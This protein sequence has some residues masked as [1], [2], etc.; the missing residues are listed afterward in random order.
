MESFLLCSWSTSC[1][2]FSFFFP[3]GF[4]ILRKEIKQSSFKKFSL[5]ILKSLLF[6]LIISSTHSG[7]KIT[8]IF[9]DLLTLIFCVWVVATCLSRHMLAWHPWRLK[10]G[11]RSLGTG[12]TEGYEWLCDYWELNLDHLQ[13]QRQIWTAE[14]SLI[15]KWGVNYVF[16]FKENGNLHFLS[17]WHSSHG[18]SFLIIINKVETTRSSSRTESKLCVSS[19]LSEALEWCSRCCCSTV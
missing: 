4:S 13:E 14:S 6:I 2:H 17:V 10:I 1:F 18:L 15:P 11:I 3:L 9:K 5:K 19:K 12:V 16:P 8:F 7:D